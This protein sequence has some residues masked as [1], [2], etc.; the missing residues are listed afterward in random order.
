MKQTEAGLRKNRTSLLSDMVMQTAPIAIRN[1]LNMAS[2]A[3]ATL[4]SAWRGGG[5]GHKLKVCD[6]VHV[7]QQTEVVSF[8]QWNHSPSFKT[9]DRR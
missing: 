2:M 1:R 8:T 5:G 6:C 7:H 4:R 3:A 9:E